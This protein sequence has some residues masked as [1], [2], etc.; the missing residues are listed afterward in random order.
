VLEH[1]SAPGKVRSSR[2][3]RALLAAAGVLAG[4]VASGDS[5]ATPA[6]FTFTAPNPGWV[7][8]LNDGLPLTDVEGD[9]PGGRD[10]VG[11]AQNPMLYIASDATHLYLRLRVDSDPLQTPTNF[12]PFGWGCF[13]NT[14]ANLQTYEL[15]TIIDGVS[16]PDVIHFYKN[17]MTASPNSPLEDPDLPPVQAV[18]APL[19]AAVGHAQV[20]SAPSM[21]GGTPDFFL[22]WA[23]DLGA[24]LAAGFDP[25]VPA[26]YYC[27]SAN[28]GTN[29]AAD[30]SGSAA[31]GCPLDSQFS[32]PI[33]CGPLG[34]AICGDGMVA[35]AEGCD[36]GNLT[37]GDGCDSACLEELGQTCSGDGMCAS[38][39][40]DP[41]GSVCACDQDADC[42]GA[43]LCDT[44]SDPNQCFDQTCGDGQIQ[45]SEG[46]DDQ[47]TAS[48]DGCSA[49]CAV[50]QDW[51]CEGE[52]S[53]CTPAPCAGDA[54]CPDGST[55]DEPTGQCVQVGCAGDPD[56][57]SGTVCDEAVSECV[58]CT[59]D[60]HC[61]S[62][63][64]CDEGARVCAGCTAD[65]DCLDGQVC[66]DEA[67]TCVQCL[68]DLDCGEG[69]CDEASRAC[70]E[71]TADAECTA[72]DVCDELTH[73]CVQCTADAE[74]GSGA[75]DETTKTCEASALV[76]EGNGL[77]CAARSGGAN[78]DRAA[79]ALLG[80]LGLGL[81]RRRRRG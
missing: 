31:G 17:T 16:N 45:G 78:G 41:A 2:R 44:T 50:E 11:D 75:C 10:I 6:T 52:P 80:L 19:T 34:C 22:Q 27:G 62:G 76:T 12:G 64:V 38:G 63:Q 48:G 51:V 35:A 58:E 14:D 46:C 33:G 70:V 79:L 73:V 74:C 1:R 4:L 40:C 9:A 24:A 30:C 69:V 81:A 25:A 59:A 68:G 28:N 60:S 49:T 66:D 15:S 5:N 47:N 65:T 42:P 32:D 54:D 18:T 36:D 67:R 77:L 13:I 57:P 26:N 55:C 43:Q 21:F 39:F 8:V 7:V 56:C 53:L 3:A 29:L 72:G 20:V 37:N 23:V 61:P 71:C